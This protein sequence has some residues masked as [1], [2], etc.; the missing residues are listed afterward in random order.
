MK[1]EVKKLEDNIKK[2]KIKDILNKFITLIKI[3][4]S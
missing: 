1:I 2:D 4:H 3:K